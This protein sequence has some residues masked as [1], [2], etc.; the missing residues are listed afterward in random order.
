MKRLFESKRYLIHV[1]G[2]SLLFL[3]FELQSQELKDTIFDIHGLQNV[4]VTIDDSAYYSM[5]QVKGSND[6][7]E[8][9]RFNWMHQIVGHQYIQIPGPSG[10]VL[11]TTPNS[12]VVQG[13][14]KSVV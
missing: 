1:I 5:A 10:D 3:G 2:L 12:L 13:D 14:R 8:V 9:Y 4:A 11:F 6:S 7:L